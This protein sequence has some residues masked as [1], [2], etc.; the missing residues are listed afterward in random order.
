[1]STPKRTRRRAYK[2]P[3]RRRLNKWRNRAE[4]LIL[5]AGVRGFRWFM[6]EIELTQPQAMAAKQAGVD[7]LARFRPYM[8]TPQTQAEREAMLSFLLG[9][10]FQYHPWH[11]ETNNETL[12]A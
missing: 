1:M 12:S 2:T 8:G 6:R 4:R 11:R 10:P 5:R 3:S 7:L 9:R